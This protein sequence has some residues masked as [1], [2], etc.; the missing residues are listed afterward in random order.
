MRLSVAATLVAGVL[1]MGAAPAPG[2]PYGRP[3]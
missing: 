3:Q 2:D 1:L